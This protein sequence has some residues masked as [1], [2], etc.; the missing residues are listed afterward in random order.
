[1]KK[2]RLTLKHDSGTFNLITFA[3]SKRQA[4]Y[5]V[6]QAEGCPERAIVK[7]KQG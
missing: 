5:S 2:F 6:C 4:I 7:I 1:M 3:R